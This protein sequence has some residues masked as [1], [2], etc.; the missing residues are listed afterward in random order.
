ML[1]VS[2]LFFYYS[3]VSVSTVFSQK[4]LI[5]LYLS[6]LQPKRLICFNRN[7]F[8]TQ[9]AHLLQSQLCFNRNCSTVSVSTVLQQKRLTCF[10][11]NCFA[12][13]TVHL[14]QSQLFQPKLLI[15]FNRSCSS[16]LWWQC[17]SFFDTKC[18]FSLSRG[19]RAV[20]RAGKPGCVPE[21]KTLTFQAFA[22][23]G[24]NGICLLQPSNTGRTCSTFLSSFL[25]LKKV[26]ICMFCFS[27]F[28]A[29]SHSVS[30]QTRR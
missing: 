9:T 13:E 18:V 2:P 21:R 28:R 17:Q 6:C 14:S 25:E 5:C 16:I 20:C 24:T 27:K 10:S 22:R 29:S 19:L 26:F 8:S 15:C 1:V 11:L 4:L 7:C 12:N 23:N 3:S 30:S